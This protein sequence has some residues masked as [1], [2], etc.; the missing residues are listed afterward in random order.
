MG[1]DTRKPA[2]PQNTNLGNS[3]A[4]RLGAKSTGSRSTRKPASLPLPSSLP[5]PSACA[6]ELSTCR[7]R[8]ALAINSAA[9]RPRSLVRHGHVW[10]K[11]RHVTSWYEDVYRQNMGTPP[12]H[13]S[14]PRM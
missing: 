13:R 4:Q 5:S 8:D 2:Q 7:C 6:I 10:D 1:E 14:P 9:T 3:R 11:K 12:S